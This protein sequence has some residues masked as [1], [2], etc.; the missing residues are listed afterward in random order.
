MVFHLV[1]VAGLVPSSAITQMTA[2]EALTLLKSGNARFASGNSLHPR[3]SFSRISETAEQ[4][5]KPFVT[6]LAGSDSRVPV[7]SLFDQG[8]GDIFTV[9]VAGNV[10]DT[11]EAG[12]IE[13]G[14]AHLKT[15]LLVIL[16]NSQCEIVSGV[17]ERKPL[18]GNISPLVENIVPAIERAVLRHPRLEG[19]E[20]LPHAIEENVS[21]SIT[22]LLRISSVAAKRIE[23]GDLLV[24]GGVYDIATGRVK[25]LSRHPQVRMLEQR[26]IQARK[27]AAAA[28]AAEAAKQA[29]LPRPG[30]SR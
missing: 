1:L 6:V 27:E 13:Y 9:R 28:A 14:V 21:Q 24:V 7:E 10:V 22:D 30:A 3:L 15:P 25:W 18:E 23:D 12:S 29:R 2:P 4:G 26:G 19:P 16:G 5:Q 11:D 8:I 20:L 17:A